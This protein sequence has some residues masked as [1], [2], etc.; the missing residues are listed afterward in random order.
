MLERDYNT[1][2]NNIIYYKGF[3]DKNIYIFWFEMFSKQF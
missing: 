2:I 3:Q 1:F